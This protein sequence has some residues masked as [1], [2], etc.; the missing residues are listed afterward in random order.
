MKNLPSRWKYGLV[1]VLAILGISSSGA[2]HS[3]QTTKQ[4]TS[5]EQQVKGTESLKVAPTKIR[6]QTG[7]VVSNRKFCTLS[8]NFDQNSLCLG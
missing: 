2:T 6:I 8:D 3:L 4:T 5:I 1:A 7:V